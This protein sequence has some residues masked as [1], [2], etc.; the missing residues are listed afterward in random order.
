MIDAKNIL[1]KFKQRWHLLLYLEV[2]LYTSGSTFL[3]YILSAS[4]LLTLIVFLIIGIITSLVIKPWQPSLNETSSYIDNH[5]ETLEHSTSLLLK[6]SGNLS[7]IALLQQQKVLERLNKE[8]R[9]INPP[10]H[11]LRSAIM[12]AVLIIIGFLSSHLNLFDYFSANKNSIDQ[13]N[14]IRFQPTDSIDVEASIPQLINQTLIVDYPSYTNLRDIKSTKMS[15][16]AV[17]GSQIKWELEFNKD[18]QSVSIESMATSLPMQLKDGIYIQY[19]ML[20]QPGFY[21]F[22]F[23]DTNGNTYFSDL[24]AIEVSKDISPKIEIKDIEQFTQFEYTDNKDVTFKSLITDDYGIND[25]FIIATVSKGSGE[26]VKFREEQLNFDTAV[27]RGKKTQELLKTINLDAMKMEPGD[28]LYFYVQASDL[29]TPNSNRTRSET[30]FLAIKDTT[31]NTFGVEG[32]LGVDRM[33]DYFRSQRQLIIDTEKLIKQ[34]LKLSKEDFNFKSNELGFDQKALRIKYGEF[35]GEEQADGG[36]VSNESLS[37]FEMEQEEDH[38]DEDLLDKYSHK[39]D[40]DNEHNLVDE[41]K[42][43]TK[44]PLE[45][46][47]HGHDDAEMATLFEESLRSKL[48]KALGEMWDSEL[49]LRL[50]EPEKS[51]PY[52]YRTLKL[53]QDIKNSARIYVHRIGFDPPPIKEDKRLSGK[54]KDINSY[55]KN[56]A[57]DAKKEF[58]FIRKAIYRIEQIININRGITDADQ[59]LF[60]SAGIELAQKAIE[61]PGQF[62]SALQG[63]KELSE[64]KNTTIE[65][66]RTVQK[67]LLQALPSSEFYPTKSRRFTSEIN[68]L[69]L[70][71][72]ETHDR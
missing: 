26:S 13:E 57:F 28:E 12:A 11:V 7:S 66:L 38:G 51:L 70:K 44:N 58:P 59:N 53:L 43:V 47:S 48:L 23:T 6:P 16:N 49:Y 3:V 37:D 60:D 17:E 5:L 31:I 34:R 1:I 27:I 8:I 71:E 69:L 30:F 10:N 42:S 19:M 36:L 21:N 20:L 64:T 54:L 65:T 24:Y 62:L 41:K 56:E 35:M 14:V 29:K 63:L 15:V 22:K 39:H 61:S 46:F 2:L 50:Y 18:L 55:R 67:G 25:S 45:E 32:T 33:P 40:G 52:Q 4:I 72:L 68:Q 9:T